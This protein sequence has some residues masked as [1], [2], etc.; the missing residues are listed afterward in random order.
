MHDVKDGQ[1]A[2]WE[3]LGHHLEQRRARAALGT[4]E[5]VRTDLTR[6]TRFVQLVLDVQ[7]VGDG[8]QCILPGDA[9]LVGAA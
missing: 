5:Q 7:G 4:D 2:R 1:S 8:V 9:V 3:D 6:R